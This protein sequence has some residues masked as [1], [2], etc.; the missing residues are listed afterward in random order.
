MESMV[1]LNPLHPPVGGHPSQV[2]VWA[3]SS[4]AI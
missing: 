1:Y 4:Y 2:K 3:M